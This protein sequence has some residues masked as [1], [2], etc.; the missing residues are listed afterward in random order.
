[1]TPEE[2]AAATATAISGIASG[3]MLDGATYAAGG[4]AGFAGLDFYA[5]G[6]AGV[7]GRVDADVVA[8]AFAFFEPGAVRGFWEQALTVME[9]REASALFA[10]CGHRWAAAHLG[11]DVDWPRLADLLGK[12]T[13]AASPAVAPLFAAW[14]TMEEPAADEAGGRALALHRLNVARELR[15]ALH[16]AAVIAHGLRPVEALVIRS[17]HMVPLFGWTDGVPEPDA[18]TRARW[19]DAEAATDRAMAPAYE[20]LDDAERRELASLCA[21]ASRS[22]R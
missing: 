8:A 16:A 1:M 10:A 22:V 12:V 20:A 11:D 17:P 19:Q 15:N 3:F 7:L 18:A 6:R 14:R 5:A 21:A 9:P 13:A 2:T 4:E